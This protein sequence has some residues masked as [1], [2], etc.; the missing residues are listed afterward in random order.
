M[1]LI[2]SSHQLNNINKKC[3]TVINCHLSLNEQIHIHTCDELASLFDVL[4]CQ[5]EQL[6]LKEQSQAKYIFDNETIVIILLNNDNEQHNI[7]QS[8]RL[9]IELFRFIQH[10]NNITQWCLTLVIAIDYNELNVLSFDYIEGLA[11][12]YARYLREECLIMNRIHV[13][14]KIYN[15]LKENQFYEFH[16]YSWITNKN[17]QLTYFL[18]SINMYQ[19]YKNFST[20]TNN[21]SM[22]D[23]L[24]R[25]QAQYHV[26]KHLGT[27]TLT[28]SLRKRS[29]VEL[30]TKYLY[31]FNL[32]FK[33]QYINHEENL[34]QDFQ[35][36]HRA[37][38]PKFFIYV[39][40]L[41]I[42]I[43]S[44]CQSFV[45]DHLTLYYIILFPTIILVLVLLIILFL[46]KINFNQSQWNFD[47]K[48]FHVYLNILICLTLS[49]LFIVAIQYHS[50]QNFKSL[51]ISNKL[52]NRTIINESS[53]QINS[54]L[55]DTTIRLVLKTNLKI[56]QKN[57]LKMNRFLFVIILRINLLYN[58]NND[59]LYIGSQSRRNV[60]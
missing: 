36:K 57:R 25:I 16:S 39:F 7:D 20:S 37:N 4:C 45:I 49:T 21:S 13:S 11:Y 5:I 1:I 26:E 48:K 52:I 18:F 23:Q 38:R 33:E 3:G 31:W 9:A 6:I 59:E 29:L 60:K 17:D 8:C 50:I 44:L 22:I 43:G 35:L 15:T 10:V 2:T 58:I 47:D 56:M 53:S 19:P 30:T 40:I 12:D 32:N 28:R 27:I 51:L 14:S 55:N 34:N 24:T 54:I 41:C 46:Y 42:L